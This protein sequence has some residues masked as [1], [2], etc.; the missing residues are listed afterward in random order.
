M[1]SMDDAAVGEEKA[2]GSDASRLAQVDTQ[3]QR[4]VSHMG[5]KLRAD[6][7]RSSQDPGNS[8]HTHTSDSGDLGERNF[9]SHT[10]YPPCRSP[11]APH[12][13]FQ[14]SNA[15]AQN[16]ARTYQVSEKTSSLNIVAQ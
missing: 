15:R 13:F 5:F 16:S 6:S 10:N 3:L 2:C 14:I 1:E 4:N 8:C 9:L 7:R 11:H 12:Y